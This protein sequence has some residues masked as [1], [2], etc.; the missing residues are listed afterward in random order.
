MSITRD[1]KVRCS[2]GIPVDVT[3][4]D[5]LNAGRH[6]HLR[7][8][9]LDRTLHAFS[10]PV[11]GRTLVIEKHMLYFDFERAQFF[12][13]Y[14]RHELA[15]EAECSRETKQAYERWLRTDAP[16]FI[17]DYG[18]RFLVRTCFGYEELREKLVID[19]AQLSD[20]VIEALK[21]DILTADPWFRE[22][23]VVTL[24]L[25]RVLESGELGFVPEWPT[26]PAPELR[27]KVV[28]VARAVYDEI[29][30]RFD[31]IL[32]TY[33]GLAKGAHVSLLRLASP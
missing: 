31:D 12:C 29:D 15:L 23:D 13:V 30:A 6:P 26:T 25:D 16:P 24:R 2:C 1:A 10:C 9:V 21:I 7:Q 33:P 5:S 27:N 14:P 32:A 22:T 11:C 18:K 17:I 4:A 3:V 8:A 28:T 20:I 19:D